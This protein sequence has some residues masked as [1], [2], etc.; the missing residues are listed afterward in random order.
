MIVPTSAAP[1]A[2][3]RGW[4]HRRAAQVESTIGG[5]ARLRVIVLLAAVLGLNTADSSTV[6][7]IAPELEPALHISNTEIGLLVAI[8]TGVG[9]VAT[10]PMGVL[11]DR[12]NRTRLLWVS[13]LIWSLG[14]IANGLSASF[15]TLLITRCALGA[16]VATAGPATSSLIGDLFPSGERTRIWGYILTGELVGSGI[17]FLVS[18]NLAG[19]M[20][21]RAGFLWL[22]APG[23]LLAWAIQRYLPEPARGGR[24]RLQPSDTYNRPRGETS[25]RPDRGRSRS[26]IASDATDVERQVREKHIAPHEHLVLHED[27]TQKSLWW[28]VRYV[29][30]VPTNRLLIVASALGYFF[31]QG[32]QTFV[33]VFMRGR[34]GLGQS[35]AS[36]IVVVLGAGAIAGVLAS[37]QITDR[38]IARGHITARPVVAGSAFLLAALLFIPALLI[39]PLLIAAPL[40]FLAAA[41]LGATNPPMDAARLDLMHSRLWGRAEA[42]RTSLRTALQAISPLAFGYV[43]TL[44][45]GQGGFGASGTAQPY[46]AGGLDRTFLI[47]LI[48][49]LIGGLLLLLR[50]RRTYPRDVATALCSEQQ[51]SRLEAAA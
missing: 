17:G 11:S 13:I 33:V 14:M 29:L 34:F 35:V 18:G 20:S 41:A 27:P 8:T 4:L 19:A 30:A 45:G 51:L 10:L 2:R 37:G 49:V 22:A 12:V 26:E 25:D 48:A 44:F 7:A 36:T 32:I 39:S 23:L 21:W 40:M 31:L 1:V 24:S 46:G 38:L 50:A 28:S 43:S 47:M 15:S 16:V 6:G 9:V 42:V 3:V 5:P